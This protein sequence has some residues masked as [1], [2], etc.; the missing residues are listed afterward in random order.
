M[1]ETFA[2]TLAG[3]A[4]RLA[5]DVQHKLAFVADVHR[6]WPWDEQRWHGDAASIGAT[7]KGGRSVRGINEPHLTRPGLGRSP[8][9]HQ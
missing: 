4:A 8:A 6:A 3:V 7:L 5:L 2:P 1:H 9:G